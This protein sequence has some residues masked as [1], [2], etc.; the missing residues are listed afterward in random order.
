MECNG[1]VLKGDWSNSNCGQTAFATKGGNTF[2]LKKYQAIVKPIDNGSLTKEAF[3]QNEAKFNEFVKRHQKINEILRALSGPGGNII[4]P[5]EEFIFGNHLVESSLF[6]TGAVKDEDLPGLIKKLTPDQKNL[7]L[8]SATGALMAVHRR[9]IIH[10]DLK[11]K[12]IL[13]VKSPTGYV[14]KLIDFDSSY[15]QGDVPEEVV[16]DINYYSPELATYS[17]LEDDEEREEYKTKLTT[18]SDIFSLGLIFHYYLTGERV[19]FNKLNPRLEKR[20]EAGKTIYPWLVLLN[21]GE[22]VLSDKIK[23][24]YLISLLNDMLSINP[25]DRPDANE[26]LMRLKLKKVGKSRKAGIV[27]DD[28]QVLKTNDDGTYDYRDALGN[29]YILK[30]EGDGVIIIKI[31]TLADEKYVAPDKLNNKNL[32]AF[33]DYALINS[34]DITSITFGENIINIGK[35]AFYQALNLKEVVFKNN[36]QIIIGEEAFAHCLSLNNIRIESSGDITLLPLA[37]ANASN[38]EEVTLIGDDIYISMGAFAFD[39]G[40]ET[41][42]AKSNSLYLDKKVFFKSMNIK[43][44]LI[45][46][47]NSE[48]SEEAYLE[49]SL[50]VK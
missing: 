18:K 37:F 1:Y 30:D 41:I 33:S 23:D 42:K 49:S 39:K 25:E 11:L 3:K 32:T 10:S 40:L 46:S 36:K 9:N 16:G 8:I 26:V 24:E 21:D 35:M 7:L 5:Y 29:V 45:N 27:K 20:V 50:L 48:I 6:V 44:F 14:A 43:N 4:S 31:L 38:L 34:R 22:L 17:D 28:P 2:I 13:V 15:I 12:N 47:K 19:T